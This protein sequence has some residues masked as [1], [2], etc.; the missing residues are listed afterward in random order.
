MIELTNDISPINFSVEGIDEIA[1]NIRTILNTRKGS[2]PLDRD[3][4]LSWDVVDLPGTRFLQKMKIEV[5]Q[6][7]EKYEPR[8]KV[9]EVAIYPDESVL[10]GIYKIKLKLE[11]ISF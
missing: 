2:V 11:I 9:R 3:F 1:Q 5:V 6:Q 8:V 7:I 10:D 4:G